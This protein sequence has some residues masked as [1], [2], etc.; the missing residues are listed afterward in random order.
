MVTLWWNLDT[1]STRDMKRTAYLGRWIVKMKKLD[2]NKTQNAKKM[3]DPALVKLRSRKIHLCS[4]PTKDNWLTGVWTLIPFMLL[5]TPSLYPTD[6]QTMAGTTS[7]PPKFFYQFHSHFFFPVQVFFLTF[8]LI[9]SFSAQ[10]C[11]FLTLSHF[12]F[13]LNHIVA[14][15]KKTFK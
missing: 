5:A 4:E 15:K 8:F 10:P 14:L 9:F 11:F 3:G 12:Y 2:W 6:L 7:C 1:K 13:V